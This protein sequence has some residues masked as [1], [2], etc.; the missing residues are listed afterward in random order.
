MG[1]GTAA[2]AVVGHPAN[3]RPRT[4]PPG[5]QRGGEGESF[6]FP[7][8]NRG[9][10]KRRELSELVLPPPGWDGSP[11]APCL[12]ELPKAGKKVISAV[13]SPAK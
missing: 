7:R 1:W 11:A 5:P 10:D 2:S 12:P 9:I 6:G 3:T 4:Q 8:A 13:L